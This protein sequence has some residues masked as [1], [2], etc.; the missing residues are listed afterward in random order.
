MTGLAQMSAACF[1]ARGCENPSVIANQHKAGVGRYVQGVSPK[2]LDTSHYVFSPPGC[3]PV[4]SAAVRSLQ[5]R[6]TMIRALVRA[7][8]LLCGGLLS[9]AAVAQPAPM[10]LPFAKVNELFV[11]TAPARLWFPN[12]VTL[13]RGTSYDTQAPNIWHDV[14]L[15]PFGVAADA[16]AA[17]LRGLLIITN[18]PLACS[19]AVTSDCLLGPTA[20]LTLVFRAP[21]DT[22]TD[23]GRV[24]G[25]VA[26]AH[27]GGGQ[28]SG[29]ASWVPLVNGVTQVCYRVTTSGAWPASA[30][31]G[32]NLSVQ[33]WA[34]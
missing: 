13:F 1:R 10:P 5:V 29:F 9:F 15:K 21:G 22:A 6:T 18:A 24:M 25:Q 32:I 33:A 20:D 12:A 17:D 7:A 3:W 11:S 34:R 8:A 14:D 23:C 30:S 16:I 28:R 2:A 31:Y 4:A 26:E 19:G 27:R